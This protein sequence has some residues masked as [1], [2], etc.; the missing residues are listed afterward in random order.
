M[1]D[2]VWMNVYVTVV[3]G[4]LDE[5]KAMAKNWATTHENNTPEILGYEWF[6][7]SAD[8][9]KVQVMECYASSEALSD[10]MERGGG[11]T[12]K[13]PYPYT[14]DKMEICGSISDALRKKLDSGESKPEYFDHFEG[15]SRE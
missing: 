15:F 2:R 1:S 12:F 6:Y 10:Y 14:V 3:D 9:M 7:R 8:E 13:P 11:G 4:K 5:F